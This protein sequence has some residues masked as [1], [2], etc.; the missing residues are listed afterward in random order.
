[1][2]PERVS[3]Y[4]DFNVP[5]SPTV[6]V[7][8]AH[9]KNTDENIKQLNNKAEYSIEKAKL[10]AVSVYENNE[11]TRLERQGT[12]LHWLIGLMVT[13]IAMAD[14]IMCNVVSQIINME[15]E[16]IVTLV[17]D[18]LKFYIGSTVA[19]FIAMFYFIVKGTF[20]N[21]HNNIMKM[22]LKSDK[23]KE[24]NTDENEKTGSS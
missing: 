17:I 21:S 6:G 3:Q 2:P 11:S 10:A 8:D 22:L 12:V 24:N 5:G 23:S 9:P 18:I 15:N 19:E 13:Q 16:S 1:M 4:H 14:I 7:P 20:T